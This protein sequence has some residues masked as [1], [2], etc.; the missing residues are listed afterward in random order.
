VASIAFGLYLLGGSATPPC[1]SVQI[2]SGSPSVS[3]EG[4]KCKILTDR[5]EFTL[6]AGFR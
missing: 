1:Y 4:K 6:E 3:A 2:D 5:L